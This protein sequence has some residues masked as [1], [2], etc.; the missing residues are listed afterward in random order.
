M[1]LPEAADRIGKAFLR[2]DNTFNLGIDARD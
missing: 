2:V 1:I